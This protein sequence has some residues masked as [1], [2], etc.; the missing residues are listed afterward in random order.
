MRVLL[1]DKDLVQGTRLPA[2][3][4]SPLQKVAAAQCRPEQAAGMPESFAPQVAPTPVGQ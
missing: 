2:K 1:G 3:N 4:T